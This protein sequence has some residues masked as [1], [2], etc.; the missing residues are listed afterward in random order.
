MAAAISAI[1]NAGH[2][3]HENVVPEDMAKSFTLPPESSRVK[4]GLIDKKRVGSTIT[5]MPRLAVLTQECLYFANPS[6]D[7]IIDHIPLHEINKVFLQEDEDE[8][9]DDYQE[10]IIETIPDGFNSGRA[11][12]HRALRKDAGKWSEAIE[13]ESKHA[14]WVQEEANR[15]EKGPLA[16][17]RL[18]VKRVYENSITQAVIAS[19]IMASFAI[20]LVQAEILPEDGSPTQDLFDQMDIFFASVFCFELAVNLFA[21]SKN[22]CKEFLSDGWNLLDVIIVSLSLLT[23]LASGIPSLK[24]FR[25]IRVFRVARVFR[26]LKSLNRIITALASAVIPVANSFIILA[27]VTCIWAA[28]GTHFFSARSEAFFG[29]FS[30][31]L[32]TVTQSLPHL[33]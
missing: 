21:K 7:L 19:L 28:L 8:S 25:L 29:T 2:I 4:E 16:L 22:W 1:R 13:R 31:S 18:R 5:W 12:I 27:L 15:T 24:V 23:V 9:N 26:K 20:D 10:I 32:F 6:T 3:V 30:R 11:Y 17:W 33:S 14:R